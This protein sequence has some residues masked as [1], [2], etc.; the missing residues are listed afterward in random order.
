M[1][2]NLEDVDLIDMDGILYAIYEK[3]ELDKGKSAILMRSS[4]LHGQ[5]VRFLSMRIVIMSLLVYI[6][7]R[8][9][10]Y[11]VTVVIKSHQI[12]FI[13]GGLIIPSLMKTG[14][15]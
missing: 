14:I 5:R 6:G 11:Y 15:V 9:D 10:I 8:T 2:N 12:N 13:V 7:I 3:E 1:N 4:I